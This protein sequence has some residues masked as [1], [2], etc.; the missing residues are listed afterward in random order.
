MILKEDCMFAV[1]L[2]LTKVSREG[3]P[4]RR[5]LPCNRRMQ[6][7]WVTLLRFACLDD[8]RRHGVFVG[9]PEVSWCVDEWDH[10]NNKKDL[11][12]CWL[13]QLLEA[14]SLVMED[15]PITGLDV[16]LVRTNI[17]KMK[18]MLEANLYLRSI[19]G[20]EISCKIHEKLAHATERHKGKPTKE[21]CPTEIRCVLLE[22]DEI[23]VAECIARLEGD[24][25]L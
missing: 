1:T 11:P 20:M 2:W 12:I 5:I 24:A 8:K 10:E 21:E 17:R 25:S 14:V 13:T 18:K 9:T 7:T 16:I 19:A 23:A 6:V 3:T 15:G 22:L 4:M